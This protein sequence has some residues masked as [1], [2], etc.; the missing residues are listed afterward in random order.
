MHIKLLH[1]GRLWLFYAY[2]LV[3]DADTC[4]KRDFWL[5]CY[6]F[7]FYSSQ[8]E[9][10]VLQYN[11]QVRHAGVAKWPITAC[12]H[13]CENMSAMEKS[14]G[15]IFGGLFWWEVAEL[16]MLS[17]LIP[18]RGWWSW[19]NNEWNGEYINREELITVPFNPRAGD[20]EIIAT[21]LKWN[22]KK[23]AIFLQNM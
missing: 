22:K 23:R 6:S 9:V 2:E 10:D 12:S 16:Q 17:L 13:T 3:C 14:S 15:D 18:L 1:D 5:S 19:W 11:C 20:P 8:W 7:W 4:L 21:H